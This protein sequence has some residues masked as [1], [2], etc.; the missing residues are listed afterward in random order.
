MK[1]TYTPKKFGPASIAVIRQAEAICREYRAA[2]YDLTLRQLYYQFVARGLIPNDQKQYKRLG[3]IINDARLAGW[4]DWDYLVDRTRNTVQR[5]HWNHPRDIIQ[6]SAK[7]FHTDWWETQPLHVEVWVEKEALAGIVEQVT[8]QYDVTSLACRGYLSQSEAWSAAQRF[9]EHVQSGR[10]V[11]II[12]LGDHDPSGVDMSRDNEDRIRHFLHGDLLRNAEI[13]G[14]YDA[15][16]DAPWDWFDTDQWAQ[17]EYDIVDTVFELRRIALNRDQ[18][19]RYQPPP[20]PAK[21]TD[22]RATDYIRKHGTQSWELDALPPDVI[23]ALIRDEI[24]ELMDPEAFLKARQRE[25][26][27]RERIAALLDQHGDV[28]DV[29][30]DL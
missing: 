27:Y 8:S 10:N 22:S 23:S 18:I 20:N 28:L 3:D 4:L 15:Y 1:I 24:E 13:S 7:Q 6:A 21:I 19:T 5:P 9:L 30:G 2:G 12:H 11:V 25:T 14:A 26:A 29:G 16:D 17:G